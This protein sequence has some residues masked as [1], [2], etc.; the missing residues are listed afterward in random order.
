MLMTFCVIA[1]VFESKHLKREKADKNGEILLF[2]RWYYRKHFAQIRYQYFE[3][4]NQTLDL[5]AV[6]LL[7]QS[8][9]NL[10]LLFKN[11]FNMLQKIRQSFGMHDYYYNSGFF[12]C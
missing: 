1:N 8:Q 3:R 7:D 2:S 5:F 6:R 11:S 12:I 10:W 9:R 4:C